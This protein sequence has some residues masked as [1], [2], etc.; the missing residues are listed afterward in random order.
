MNKITLFLLFLLTSLVCFGQ[1]PRQIFQ[2]TIN[3]IDLRKHL[4]YIASDELGGRDTGSE[5]QKKAAD[6]IT[7]HLI[8]LGISPI[9]KNQDGKMGYEQSIELYKNGWKDSYVVIN[10]KKKVFFN[11]Y[12][13][14]GM[15]NIPVEKEIETVFI[16]YGIQNETT[17]DFHKKRSQK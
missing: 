7:N 9:V 1:S 11:D 8:A 10:G 12:F 3:E 14:V 15:I 4:S 16:G 17:N 2:E 6:Y 13:P 5:G